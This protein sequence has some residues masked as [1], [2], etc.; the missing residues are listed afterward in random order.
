MRILAAALCAL[1]FPVAARADDLILKN[2]RLAES[3]YGPVKA[4]RIIMPG[5]KV[6]ILF[7]SVGIKKDG[8]ALKIKLSYNVTG[9]DGKSA[10]DFPGEETGL[11]D[12]FARDYVR[13]YVSVQF[14][15]DIPLGK[16]NIAVA[17]EDVAGNKSAKAD[18]PIEVVAPALRL[19]NLRLG[20]DPKSD[21]EH[22][23]VV[24][25]G[26][27][28]CILYRI[29]GLK[30]DGGKAHVQQD[31]VI[32]DAAGKEISRVPNVIDTEVEMDAKTV[33]AHQ[34]INF[35]SAGT[36]KVKIVLRDVLA[37]KEVVQGLPVEVKRTN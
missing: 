29:A 31:I 6:H 8:N 22:G 14:S 3:E 11:I 16:Y 27:S 1:L 34:Q 24:A 20:V 7:D 9:A 26:E 19:M 15:E 12:P 2:L 28:L 23:P 17:I 32:E 10:G 33:P 18:V 35:S 30:V 21:V 36:Y 13:T 5:E 37:G 25:E 4:D